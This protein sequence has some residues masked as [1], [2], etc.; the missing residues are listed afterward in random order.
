VRPRR[1]PANGI[2]DAKV[3]QRNGESTMPNPAKRNDHSREPMIRRL[4]RAAGEINPF[5]MVLAIG[6]LILNLTCGLALIALHSSV[7]RVGPGGASA[8]AHLTAASEP[9]K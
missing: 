2:A 4:D 5:L 6:L 7:T 1:E 9:R 8:S 3:A